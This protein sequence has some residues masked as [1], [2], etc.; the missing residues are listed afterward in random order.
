MAMKSRIWLALHGLVALLP[1]IGAVARAPDVPLYGSEVPPSL[2]A[3]SALGWKDEQVQPAFQSWFETHIG[4]RGTMV[5]TDNAAQAIVIGEAK[6]AGVIVIGAERT[7]FLK[8]DLWYM[9]MRDLDLPV[10]DAKVGELAKRLASVERKLAARGKKLVVVISPSKTA[11]YPE[12]VPSGWRRER[13]ADVANHAALSARLKEHGVP[14]ADGHAMFAGLTGVERDRVFTRTGRHWTT[15]GACLVLREAMRGGAVAP[16]CAYEMA[17]ADRREAVDFDLYRLM[18]VWR[19]ESEVAMAPLLLERGKAEVTSATRRPRALFVGTSYMWMLA[20]VMRPF[21]DV[22][23]AFYYNNMVYDVS[24]TLRPIEPVD[25]ASPRW[26]GYALERDLY[27]I[28][29][30][31]TYSHGEQLPAFVETLDRRLD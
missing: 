3:L 2:P 8:D 30:L 19:A 22:P 5:R 18:N 16:S 26:A 11:V 10:V 27:V 31:E 25:P 4:F 24:E 6:P 14:F 21:V 9:G 29:I 1:V 20:E 28:E 15:L 23:V 13:R 7:L 17:A 12:A